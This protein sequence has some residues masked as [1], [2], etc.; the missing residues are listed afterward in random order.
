[1]TA[2]NISVVAHTGSLSTFLHQWA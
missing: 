2:S 1:V